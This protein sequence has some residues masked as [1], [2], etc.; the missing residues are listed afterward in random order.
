MM[1]RAPRHP[2]HVQEV[3]DVHQ[4]RAEHARGQADGERMQHVA[5]ADQGEAV[6]GAGGHA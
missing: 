2:Q 6:G 1:R 3:A 4:P 5:V